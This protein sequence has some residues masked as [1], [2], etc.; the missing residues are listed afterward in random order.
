MLERT[1][2]AGSCPVYSL[3]LEPNGHVRFVG[4]RDVAQVGERAWRIEPLFARHLLGEFERAG[5]LALAPRYPT[6]VEEFP[7]LVLSFTRAGVTHRVQLG[8]EGTGELA[9][10]VKAE[11]LLERLATTIDKL[12]SSARYVETDSKKKNGGCV[13]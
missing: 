10:E 13:E 12:T 4:V 9:R 11:R 8:G 6:E 1:A 5:F 3:T 7:G 2:C